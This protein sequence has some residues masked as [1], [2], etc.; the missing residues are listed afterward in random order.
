MRSPGRT[1]ASTLPEIAA[2]PLGKPMASSAPSSAAILAS[3]ADTVGLVVR[4]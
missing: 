4:E 2:M 1:K 3:K